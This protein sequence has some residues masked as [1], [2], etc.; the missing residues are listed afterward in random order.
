VNPPVPE[1]GIL[2]GQPKD[3]TTDV[4]AGAWRTR[5]PLPGLLSPPAAK[6][7]PTSTQH[8]VSGDDEPKPC[9]AR[10]WD[11]LEQ[12]GDQ[13]PVGPRELRSG[14]NLALKDRQLVTQEQNL[15]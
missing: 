6:D 7:V 14:V 13:C 8:R 11:R 3:Q 9:S 12:N 10:P 2:L 15:G 4:A 1:A 5:L